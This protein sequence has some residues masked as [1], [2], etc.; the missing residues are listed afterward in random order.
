MVE[1]QIIPMTV[2]Q[3]YCISVKGVQVW[4]QLKLARLLTKKVLR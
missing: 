1:R 4:E 3:K 2:A